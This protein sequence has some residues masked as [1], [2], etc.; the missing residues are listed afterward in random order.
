VKARSPTDMCGRYLTRAQ[1]QEIASRF[2]VGTNVFDDPLPPNFNV[3]PS[4]FQPIIRLERDSNQ[5]EMVLARWGLIPFF[6][7]DILHWKSF[8]TI[9]AKAETVAELPTYREA[10][11]KRR[12]LVPADGFYEWPEIEKG[13]KGV[14]HPQVFTLKNGGMMAFAG[15]WDAW[16]DKLD[17]TWLQTFTIITTEA[18]ELM[19]KIHH[20]MP[21]ILHER[22]WDRWLDRDNTEQPPKDLLRPY[23]SDEMETQL[24]N[25]AVGNV[26]NN[27][28]EM[29]DVPLAVYGLD[30]KGEVA[31]E[32]SDPGALFK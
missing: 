13:K 32:E 2:R 30:L 29:L 19:A 26:K 31:P 5:R 10:F 15:L 3:A 21:V 24:C 4:T 20:R 22:D 9:N 18:N 8:T 28:P 7:K 14:K 12:C 25:P 16:F 6:V 17:G 23:E 11:K 1:K 27:G